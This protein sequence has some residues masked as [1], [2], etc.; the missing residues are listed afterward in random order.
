MSSDH[1]WDF[2]NSNDRDSSYFG[3]DG[4]WGYKNSDGSGSYFGEDGSWGY[5]NPDGS[6]SYF[7]ADGSWGSL[8][9]DGSGSYFGADGRTEFKNPAEDNVPYEYRD[10]YVFHDFYD[11]E[12]DDDEDDDDEDEDDVESGY[13]S[14]S[15]QSYYSQDKTYGNAS[16]KGHSLT[17]WIILAIIFPYVGI[18]FL[19]IYSS[20]PEHYWHA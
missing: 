1:G 19:I 2:L 14:S 7:G 6:G 8:N 17:L 20:S 12:E 13:S 11:D 10:P 15:Q 18:P 9:S 16:L 4:S 3:S 5:K